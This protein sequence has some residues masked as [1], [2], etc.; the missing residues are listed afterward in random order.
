MKPRPKPSE[1]AEKVL[2]EYGMLMYAHT[3][4]NEDEWREHLMLI[5]CS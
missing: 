4:G 1:V 2:Q 5:G 3:K